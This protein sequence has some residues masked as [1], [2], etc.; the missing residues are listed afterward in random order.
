L[1]AGTQRAA[2]AQFEQRGSEIDP[3]IADVC[4]GG[5]SGRAIADELTTLRPQLRVL[6]ISGYPKDHLVGNELLGPDD[7]LLAKPFSPETLFRRI[8]CK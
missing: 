1:E 3:L 4:V 5:Q 7:A 2:V 6:F 8:C